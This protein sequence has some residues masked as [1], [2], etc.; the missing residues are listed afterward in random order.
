MILLLLACS[1]AIDEVTMYGTTWDTPKAEGSP[2]AGVTL[3]SL[4]D[5]A[6]TEVATT[7]SDESGIFYLAMPAGLSFFVTLEKE[8]HAPTAFSGSAGVADFYAGLGLPWIVSDAWVETTRATWSGC[9]G[10]SEGNFLVGEARLPIP[11]VDD[12][13]ALPTVPDASVTFT[14]SD[15]STATACYL[16]ETGAPDP[17]LTAT[18]S[19]GAW[20]IFGVVEGPGLVEVTIDAESGTT[21][22][23]YKA[24]VPEG[25]LAGLFPVL[26]PES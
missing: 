3:R 1:P 19:L 22:E 4:Q 14:Q 10:G 18:S 21:S 8:G 2:L 13:Q 24:L 15:G 9:A 6:T 25:G 16:D 7:E 26:V 11:D 20:A 12:V 23:I 17:E 5:D